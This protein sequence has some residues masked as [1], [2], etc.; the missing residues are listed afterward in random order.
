MN[1]STAI[2]LVL[3][4]SAAAEGACESPPGSNAGPYVERVLTRVGLK[5][6]DPWCIAHVSDVGAD[7]LGA[8]WP[9]P[10]V[11]GC[12]TLA[13]FAIAKKILFESPE[14]G[15]V[16]LIW[17]EELGRFAHGGFVIGADNDTRSGNTSGAGSRDG[18]LVGRRRW[19]FT[20]KDRF[21]RWSLLFAL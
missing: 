5:K 4:C 20:P 7:A 9:L 8:A 1:R 21:I 10:L 2:D 6:G 13:E 12:V 17:H 3:R 14:I 15:D 19:T 11:G 18:W 16:F